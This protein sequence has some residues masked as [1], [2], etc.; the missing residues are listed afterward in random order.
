[1]WRWNGNRKKSEYNIKNA[2]TAPIS[3]KIILLENI[4][5]ESNNN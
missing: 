3:D 4:R 5:E 2:I 1:M